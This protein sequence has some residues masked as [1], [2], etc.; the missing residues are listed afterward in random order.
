[1]VEMMWKKEVM[2]AK[3]G[4]W[5]VIW[6]SLENSRGSGQLDSKFGARGGGGLKCK[7]EYPWTGL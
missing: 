5:K 6:P 3:I 7:I 1:M 2:G 4:F